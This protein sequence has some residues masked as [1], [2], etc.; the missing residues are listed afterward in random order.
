MDDLQDDDLLPTID[1]RAELGLSDLRQTI[2][3]PDGDP[4]AEA[5]PDEVI[6]ER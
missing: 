5:E 3:D 1:E 2:D 6:D 4:D